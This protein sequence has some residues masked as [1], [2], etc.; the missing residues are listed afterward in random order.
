MTGKRKRRRGWGEKVK[1]EPSPI[2]HSKTSVIF[3]VVYILRTTYH[4]PLIN[5]FVSLLVL[6]AHTHRVVF[7]ESVVVSFHPSWRKLHPLALPSHTSSLSGSA[8]CVRM[9]V[10]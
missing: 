9:V 5:F 8:D 3:I 6:P 1:N 4:R 2:H 7:V 10:K